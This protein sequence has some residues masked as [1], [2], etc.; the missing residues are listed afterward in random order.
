MMCKDECN[1]FHFNYENFVNYHKGIEIH[2]YFWEL[3]LD[4]K[5]KV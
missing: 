1:V 5:S 2:S 4:K 3:F